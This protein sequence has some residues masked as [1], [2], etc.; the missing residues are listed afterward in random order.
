MKRSGGSNLHTAS[1]SLKTAAANEKNVVI[2]IDMVSNMLAAIESNFDL[3]S[4]PS[5]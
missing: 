2:H 5:L 4:L 3:F 1:S